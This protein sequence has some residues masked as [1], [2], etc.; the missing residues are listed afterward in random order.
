MPSERP[1]PAEPGPAD[2]P[3]EYGE[4][5]GLHPATLLFSS[6]QVAR[7]F[8]LPALLGGVSAG[9]DIGQ[10]LTIT[11]LVAAVPALL[12]AVGKYIT[13][14]YRI[15]GPDLVLDSGVLFRRHRVLPLRRVQ[16]IDLKE[17]ALQRL[18]GVSELRVETAS[19]GSETEAVLSVLGRQAAAA[20]QAELRQRRAGLAAREEAG[21]VEAPVR[22]V[23]R[24]GPADLAIAGATS[25]EAGIIAAGLAGLL[26]SLDELSVDIQPPDF[27][28]AALT[29]ETPWLGFLVGGVAILLAVFFAGWVFSVIGALVRYWGFVL[30]RSDDELRKAYGLLARTRGTVPLD[31]VQAVRVEESIL[32]RPLGLAALKVETA[33]G[34]PGTTQR[35]GAEAYLPLARGHDVGRLVRNVF[36]NLHYDEAAFEP[37]HPRAL[38]RARVRYSAPVVMAAVALAL[39]VDVRWLWLLALLPLC[40]LWAAA[41]YRGLGHA[42]VPGFVLARLGVWNRVTWIVPEWKIQTLHVVATPFQRRHG[43][44]TLVVDTAAGGGLSEARVVDLGRDTALALQDALA[45]AAA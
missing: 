16:N 10:I 17:S 32:R 13:F 11:L 37:A 18:F 27:D 20:L 24:L 34:A 45:T 33:G 3:D 29:P 2:G 26:Q 4:P 22:V 35:R 30:E 42:R 6:L 36:E 44:A 12:V 38:R 25:N 9:D 43:L 28:P 41:Y 21:A 39:L 7:G 19:G 8:I 40:L 5:R 1:T 15:D 31:R 14:R 23:A